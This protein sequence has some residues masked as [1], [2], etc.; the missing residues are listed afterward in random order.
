MKMLG[1]T[2]YLYE[3]E[4]GEVRWERVDVEIMVEEA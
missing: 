2:D 3:A 4:E 1:S